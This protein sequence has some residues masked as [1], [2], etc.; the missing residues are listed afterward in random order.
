MI[1]T[2]EEFDKKFNT[3]PPDVQEAMG[4]VN[5]SNT[6]QSIAQ[7]YNLHIDQMGKLT[8]EIGAM[9][10]GDTHPQQFVSK[11]QESLQIELKNAAAIAKDVNEQVFLPIRESLKKIHHVGEVGYV[12]PAPEK[13][14]P[15]DILR[16]IEEP[17]SIPMMVRAVYPPQ[18][19]I[20]PTPA[21]APAPI[22]IP[23]LPAVDPYK[24]QI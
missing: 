17:E 3:L 14:K 13:E 5:T 9:M 8:D 7:K 24:E 11:I 20:V 19:K 2:R 6:I 4:S 21:S 18:P 22:S 1:H 15:K 12:P 23:T 16:G 10:L